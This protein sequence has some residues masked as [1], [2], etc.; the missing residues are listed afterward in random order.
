MAR[1]SAADARGWQSKLSE[2]EQQRQRARRETLNP[3]VIGAPVV[4]DVWVLPWCD[5]ADMMLQCQLA[6]M[7]S[8]D[9]FWTK[10]SYLRVCGVVG[11]FGQLGADDSTDGV[12]VGQEGPQHAL[13]LSC[14]P[15]FLPSYL[16]ACRW[17]KR[18]LSTARI[19]TCRRST[20]R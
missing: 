19:R 10:H 2:A 5:R 20:T 14:P 11:A 6:Y 18:G 9:D 4:V 13:L 8:R 1:L 15:T 16:P 7:L 12:T 3:W 17:A